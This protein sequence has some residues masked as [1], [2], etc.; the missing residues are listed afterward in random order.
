MPKKK[1]IDP[2]KEAEK[3]RADMERMEQM[4]K[5]TRPIQRRSD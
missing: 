2:A 1:K 5:A 4:S 3:T